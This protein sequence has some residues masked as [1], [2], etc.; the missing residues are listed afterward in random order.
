MPSSTPQCNISAT[1]S[2]TTHAPAPTIADTPSPLV[3]PPRNGTMT[4]VSFPSIPEVVLTPSPTP[5]IAA[6]PTFASFP[7]LTSSSALVSS[8]TFTSSPTLASSPVVGSSLSNG[9]VATPPTPHDDLVREVDP[10][11]H[12]N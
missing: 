10:T 2:I 5:T 11:L 7:T 1:P 6:F 9:H 12:D 4:L 8:P 3:P